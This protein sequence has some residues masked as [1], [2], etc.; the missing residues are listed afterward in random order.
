MHTLTKSATY[1][2]P[3]EFSP[4]D[5]GSFADFLRRVRTGDSQAAAELVRKY[6]PA[7]RLEIR[8]RLR[9]SRLRRVLDSMDICQS[10]LASFFVRAA[11]GQYD[12]EVPQQLFKLLMVIARSKV[13]YQARKAR[14]QRR[15]NRRVDEV[16]L[17]SLAVAAPEPRPSQVV[18]GAELLQQFRARLTAE[19]RSLADLRMGGHDWGE[20]AAQLGGTPD[21]RRVQ[22]RRAVERVAQQIGLEA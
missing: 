20:I 16:D 9:N 4:A 3:R 22:W 11:A 6:E 7:I 8:L 21:A 1:N 17:N 2:Q 19:E 5:A 13:A 18:A 10:V 15:D 12:L 14:A